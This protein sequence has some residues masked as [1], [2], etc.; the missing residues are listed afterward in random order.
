MTTTERPVLTL[1]V[2][3][4]HILIRRREKKK[5]RVKQKSDQQNGG[6]VRSH[7]G[8]QSDTYNGGPG[9]PKQTRTPRAEE[10]A[11]S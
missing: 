11:P 1:E 8:N 5:K 3:A 4:V 2:Q 10:F 7:G 9:T 6:A